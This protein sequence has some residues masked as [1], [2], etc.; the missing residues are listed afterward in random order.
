MDDGADA[1]CPYCGQPLWI[2]VDP[3]GGRRQRF[4]TDCEICCR[5]IEVDARIDGAGGIVVD[6]ARDEDGAS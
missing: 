3:G 2:P 1:P 6:V 4:V 5:P